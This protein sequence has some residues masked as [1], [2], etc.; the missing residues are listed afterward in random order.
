MKINVTFIILFILLFSCKEQTETVK[1]IVE[2]EIE[3]KASLEGTW[4]MIGLYNYKNNLVVD[5]FKTREG[6][7]QVKMYTKSKVMWSKLVHADSTEYFAYGAYTLNDSILKETLDYG[8]KTMNLV[9]GERQDYIYKIVLEKD[10][11]SQIEIDDDGNRIYSENYK[12][13]D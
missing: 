9:I 12:R 7:R 11:F 6:N 2:V 5:S 1:D 10:K 4:E 3:E 8:S 13:V